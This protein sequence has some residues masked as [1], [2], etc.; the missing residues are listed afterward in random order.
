MRRFIRRRWKPAAFGT[1]MLAVGYL[2]GAV[3]AFDARQ[4]PAQDADQFS[5]TSDTADKIYA[6]DRALR[7][8]A[9]ALRGEGKYE[10]I[11]DGVNAF[12]VLGGGGNAREDLEN[13]AAVD[14]ETYAALYSGQAIPE[15]ADY[16]DYDDQNRLTYN[17]QVVRMYPKSRLRRIYAER[18]KL[19]DDAFRPDAF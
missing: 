13:G 10:A 5:V 16:L 19:V 9:D 1:G 18:L 7:E 6:A 3:G 8:A 14:P 11:T 2:L 15:I 17:G 12:L 4:L